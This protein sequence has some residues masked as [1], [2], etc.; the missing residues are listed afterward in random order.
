MTLIVS[1]KTERGKIVS[2]SDKRTSKWTRV[3][4]D[5]DRKSI[6]LHP[7]HRDYFL[8]MAWDSDVCQL[9][10]VA[11]S[12]LFDVLSSAEYKDDK[13]RLSALYYYI[14][15]AS[16]KYNWD[17]LEDI[18]I[19]LASTKGIYSADVRGVIY[20]HKQYA[21]IG[22]GSLIADY[23]IDREIQHW[24]R[25]TTIKQTKEFLI[26][27]LQYVAKKETTVSRNGDVFIM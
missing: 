19:L 11:Q 8:G 26:E 6:I 14:K 27:L 9:L 16:K 18:S 15:K 2:I 5:D 23:L 20:N 21:A 22:S 10:N 24:R 1:I 17:N 12:S 7:E 4:S 25:F 13:R 3:I